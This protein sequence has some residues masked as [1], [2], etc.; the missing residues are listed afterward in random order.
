M[1]YNSMGKEDNVYLLYA[2]LWPRC[3]ATTVATAASSSKAE[4]NESCSKDSGGGGGVAMEEMLPTVLV[5]GYTVR[6]VIET[7][8]R[9]V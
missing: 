2:V 7:G 1:R 4:T 8:R 5:L 3:R 9:A 6:L